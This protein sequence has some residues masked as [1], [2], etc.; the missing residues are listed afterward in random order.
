MLRTI[1]AAM[2]A[3]S[4]FV[5]AV[6]AESVTLTVTTGI[7]PSE[8]S[9][10]LQTDPGGV[11][12]ASGPSSPY[13]VSNN[14]YTETLD[15]A[16]G[17][18]TFTMLD[19]FGDGMNGGTWALSFQGTTITSPANGQNFGSSESVAFTIAGTVDTMPPTAT[20]V[21]LASDNVDPTLATDG[22]TVTLS[23]EFD[24]VLASAPTVSILGQAVTAT[25]S[26]T[27][28]TASLGITGTTANGPIGFLV[29]DFEDAAGNSGGPVSATTD[30]SSVAV[31]GTAPNLTIGGVP[32]SY[33]PGDT[34]V[35]TFTF[36]E[37]VTGFGIAD[38]A[39]SS[40]T[41]SGFSGSGAS[42]SVTVIP[43][44]TS[45]VTL[46]VATGAAQDA[47]GNPSD[48]A[49]ATSVIDSATVA[50]EMI[51]EFI[52]NRAR[53]LVQNQPNLTGFLTGRQGAMF[54]ADVTRGYGTLDVHTGS[55]GPFWFSLAGARTELD[56]SATDST[57][58]LATFGA[59]AQINSGLLVGAMLQFDYAEEDQGDGVGVSGRGWMAGPYVVAQMG[60]QPLFFEGRL[61][62]GRTDNDISPFGT[63]TDSFETERMLAMVA[64]EGIYEG[65][66]VRY[67]PR[68]QVSH[69]SERQE[70]YVDGLS[71]PVPA[72]TVRLS[73]VSAGIN[74]EMPLMP[75]DGD[76]LLTWGMSGIWSRVDGDAV[77]AAF[78]DEREGGRA[79]L[80]LG[81][82]YS[83]GEGLS[84]SADV[85]VDGVGSGEF[86]T[87]GVNL[88]V[89]FDF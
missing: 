41:L 82:R 87:Y 39:I 70:A 10:Q 55:G 4:A 26:G 40:G 76:H 84:A 6:S 63:F 35:A 73:E 17:D 89:Q 36:S 42:Y 29:S 3:I 78:I 32:I 34:F 14:V 7:F 75:E 64:L 12:V 8:N 43:G 79:R 30:G 49:S 47:A 52:E 11:T 74:F 16:P 37:P 25:G 58:A 21:S 62:Y 53:S 85:F 22:D 57:Y 24:E 65:D 71:N 31:D 28:W 44:G 2:A 54:G 45:D 77:A 80:D 33:L 23:M 27:S 18:Y 13:S 46:D 61:L 86:S 60:A 83:S 5:T 88:G 48:A 72:Q 67:F 15:L 56:G 1:F 81:Y 51:A 20:T 50:S 38:I 66:S 69:V 59:H 68:L 9:W 19:S